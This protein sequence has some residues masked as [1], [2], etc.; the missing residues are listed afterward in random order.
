MENKNVY[1]DFDKCSFEPSLVE[2]ATV[3]NKHQIIDII[4]ETTETLESETAETTK[5]TDL[6]THCMEAIFQYLEFN[7]L[8]NIVESSKQFYTASCEVYKKKYT[9]K[10]LIFD[11]SRPKDRLD[12]RYCCFNFYFGF[13]KL[14]MIFNCKEIFTF[15]VH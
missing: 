15:P 7:D 3:S 13:I 10:Y 1:T 2:G 9:G 12:F 4:E 5:I 14:K 11:P 8:L 6:N